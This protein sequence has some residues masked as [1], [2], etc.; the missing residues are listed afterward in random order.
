[1]YN[2]FQNVKKSM[3]FVVHADHYLVFRLLKMRDLKR[4]TVFRIRLNEGISNTRNR[5]EKKIEK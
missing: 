4:R 5:K 3:R 1:M 2:D